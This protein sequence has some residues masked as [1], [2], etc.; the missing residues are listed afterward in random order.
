MRGQRTGPESR[1]PPTR[2]RAPA[3]SY[4]RGQR[5]A[6]QALAVGVLC[7]LAFVGGLVAG[8][9]H[10]PASQ[11]FAETFAAAWTR[12]DY[13]AMYTQLTAADRK[14]YSRRGFLNAY[15]DT[16]RTA[17]AGSV[18]AGRPRQKDDR[19]RVP[20]TVRTRVFG[21][22]RGT[23]ELPVGDG[24]VDWSTALVFPGLRKGEKLG[25]TTRMPPR[26]GLRARDNSVLAEGD[27][28]TSPLPGV[29]A[30]V[31]GQLGDIPPD[32]ADELEGLGV[33]SGAKVGI[34]G[35]E[36]VFDDRLLGRPGG[37]LLAG[38]R[39]LEA[40]P[41]KQGGDVRTTISIGVEQA[42]IA[43]L[44]G[45]LGGVVALNPRTGTILAFAG[46]AFSGL[47]PPGSTFKIITATGAL[48]AGLTSPAR[49]YP[50][51]TK[52]TL[53][54]VDLENA[55]G[56]SCGGTLVNSFAESCNSV[57]APLGAQLGGK[58][59]VDVAQRFGFNR[60]SDIPG[61]AESTIPPAA[62]IGDDLALGSTAIGQG[63]VQATA[64]QM[65]VAAATIGLRGRRPRLTLDLATSA[66][67]L[68]TTRATTPAVAHTMERL[69]RAV[70]QFGTGTGAAIPGVAVAGKTGTAELKTTKRCQP[71]PTNIESCP[72]DQQA[73]DPTDT[74]AWFAA[75]APA[76]TGRPRTAV[77]V[78]LVGAGAGGD[79]AAPV[80][81]TV[82]RAALKATG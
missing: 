40:A 16:M 74:D 19:Y 14:T 10:K 77:G 32:R 66:R 50:V 44:A 37:E 30:E 15:T 53:E 51:L 22:I 68:R 2:G 26:A 36:R 42:A 31:V 29:A 56:E 64:L 54:G 38:R 80:A 48:E 58:R 67:G 47:Q 18:V 25:R 60:P 35:L 69:M 4:T 9:L 82:L 79:T 57:F 8:A 72:A 34:S 81:Q 33:P 27:A 41:P 76:G 78:M 3:R 55:N 12:G 11:A 59:L 65:G 21:T 46:I 49:T 39:V 7:L 70:V 61:A 73:S 28:R 1:R 24:G 20:V 23:V 71:D 43:A 6:H 45:R 13:A 63:R 52:A 62:E 75:Y 17:T 5:R